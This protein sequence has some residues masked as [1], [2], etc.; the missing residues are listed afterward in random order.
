MT[1]VTL[2][3]AKVSNRG[4]K[5][6]IVAGCSILR[7]L[8]LPVVLFLEN[9]KLLM[10]PVI[11]WKR[12]VNFTN[13]GPDPHRFRSIIRNE[14]KLSHNKN[15]AR[16]RV[17][18]FLEYAFQHGSDNQPEYNYQRNHFRVRLLVRVRCPRFGFG[19]G[20]IFVF[21]AILKA[22]AT[23]CDCGFPSEIN[24]LMLS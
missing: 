19:F 1:N 8:S 12:I 4:N 15:P 6:A 22:I 11:S 24:F 7:K 3:I 21:L 23:A 17:F 14:S 13:I 5:F 9:L 18:L 10:T 2:N 20:F 16:R